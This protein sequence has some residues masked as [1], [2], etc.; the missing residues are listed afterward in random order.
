MREESVPVFGGADQWVCM[1]EG[2]EFN[3]VKIP[4]YPFFEMII[5]HGFF[6]A[7]GAE[8]L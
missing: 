8:K 6:S 1:Y 4:P 5:D 7:Y 2:H 3:A